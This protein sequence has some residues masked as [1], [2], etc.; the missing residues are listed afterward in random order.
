MSVSGFKDIMM[1]VSRKEKEAGIVPD[2][3]VDTYMKV[4]IH[5]L[6]KS[7]FLL[8]LCTILDTVMKRIK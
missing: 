3:D 7:F 8:I 5:T 4:L 6:F 2:L 1:E